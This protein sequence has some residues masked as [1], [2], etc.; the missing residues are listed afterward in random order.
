[1]EPTQIKEDQGN[2]C[3]TLS[4]IQKCFAT[5]SSHRKSK[6][7]GDI[8]VTGTIQTACPSFEIACLEFG[9][10][11]KGFKRKTILNLE[12]K[13]KDLREK[14]SA[15]RCEK[16]VIPQPITTHKYLWL[17]RKMHLLKRFGSIE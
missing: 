11:N 9:I 1:M 16:L 7:R 3:K 12:S 14:L 8:R 17:I 2:N 13:A 10:K 6:N 4:S 15:D 5:L